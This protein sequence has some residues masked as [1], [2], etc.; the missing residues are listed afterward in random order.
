MKISTEIEKYERGW[1]SGLPETPC[2]NGS[3]ISQTEMQRKWIPR[4]V[5]KYN[6]QSIADI[7]AGALNWIELVVWPHEVQYQ[8]FDLVPRS[9]KVKQYDLINEVPPKSDLLMCIWLINHLPV[10]HAHAAV[11]NLLASGSRYL[12]YT[13][14]GVM[15]HSLDLGC[16]ESVVIG[17]RMGENFEL[18]LVEC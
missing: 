2:G 7:G 10:Y 8:P 16:I 15:D 1:R 3:R 6:I 17:N 18:R 5:E 13:W 11:K 4:M 12:M 9:K 14:W